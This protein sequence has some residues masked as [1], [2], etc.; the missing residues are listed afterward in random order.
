VPRGT[1]DSEGRVEIIP[2]GGVMERLFNYWEKQRGRGSKRKQK[3]SVALSKKPAI[4]G[5]NC[6]KSEAVIR[7]NIN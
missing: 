4:G 1:F 7:R 6:G 2:H 5:K 3:E